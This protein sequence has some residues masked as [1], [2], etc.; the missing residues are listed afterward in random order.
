[1]SYSPTRAHAQSRVGGCEELAAARLQISDLTTVRATY[2]GLIAARAAARRRPDGPFGPHGRVLVIAADHPARGMLG[3]GVR[4]AAMA[5]RREL[6]ARLVRALAHPGVSGV[7]GT[8]D[9]LEDLL[10]LGALEERFV[11]GSMNRGGLTGAVFEIDDRFTAYSARALIRDRFDAGKLLLRLDDRDPGTATALE[12]SA[13]AVSELSGVGLMAMVEPFVSEVRDGRRRNALEPEAV[14]RAIG[15]A[16]ALGDSSAHTWL[17]LPVVS[18]M[19]RVMAATTL[20]TL[21]LGGEVAEDQESTFAAWAAALA[22]PNV[23]GLVVGR[24]LLFPPDDDLDAA[25]GAA[26]GLLGGAGGAWSCG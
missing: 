19:A 24:A 5:D 12:S 6:L 3:A 26:V 23:M 9:I 20:P 4:T 7:L 14:I 17:K 15:I 13:R 25:V 18:D 11:V 1:M 21:L 8:P 16:S 10:L 22:L 2:P